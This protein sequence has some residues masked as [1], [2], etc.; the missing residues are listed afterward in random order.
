MPRKLTIIKADGSIEEQT[1]AKAELKHL[2]SLV[3]GLI[4]QVPQFTSYNGKRC[5]AWV[6]EEGRIKALPHNSMGTVLWKCACGYSDK[7]AS[8]FWYVPEVLGTLVIE[9]KA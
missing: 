3:G 4:Q 8:K 6:N 2:Q 7:T 9:Q 5:H 1:V